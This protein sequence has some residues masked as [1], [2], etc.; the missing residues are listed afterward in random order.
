MPAVVLVRAPAS[1]ANL[2]ASLGAAIRM[3]LEISIEPRRDSIEI[4]LEGEGADHLPSDDTNL[5]VK[6]MNA[7][8]DHVARRPPGYAVR[9]KNPIPV[10]SGLGSSSA[11]VVGGQHPTRMGHVGD[12]LQRDERH[13]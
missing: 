3:H 1:V 13:I 2:G 6:S 11:A 5:V 9:V 4:M 10:A 12:A 8:F 7:F